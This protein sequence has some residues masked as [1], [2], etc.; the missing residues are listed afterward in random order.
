MYTVTQVKFEGDEGLTVHLK[1]EIQFMSEVS[2]KSRKK[3][4]K[5]E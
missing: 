5:D 1:V 2:K 3:A 4:K